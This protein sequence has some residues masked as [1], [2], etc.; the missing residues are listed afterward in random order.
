MSLFSPPAGFPVHLAFIWPMIWVQVL[1]LRA[2]MRAAYGKGVQYH[3]SVSPNG[4][5]YLSSIDWIPGQKN[6]RE[7]LKPA[8][9][10]SARLADACSG[11]AYAPGYTTNPKISAHRDTGRAPG[12]HGLLSVIPGPGLRGNERR[13]ENLPLPET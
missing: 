5:V 11:R 4:I 1:L 6:E 9:Y 13:Q 8:T 7:H 2:A 12:R 3:W 10:L